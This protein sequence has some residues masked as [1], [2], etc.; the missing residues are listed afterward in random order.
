MNALGS[1]PPASQLG[2]WSLTNG[3]THVFDVAID[4]YGFARSRTDVN[5]RTLRGNRLANRR[6]G[7]DKEHRNHTS[8]HPPDDADP[9][10]ARYGGID[11]L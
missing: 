10:V 7:T 2:R 9:L 11:E 3:R 4:R 6:S 1:S 5:D 8:N